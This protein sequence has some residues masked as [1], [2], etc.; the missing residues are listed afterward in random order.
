MV[1]DDFDDDGKVVTKV[2]WLEEPAAFARKS[3]G[4]FESLK[5]DIGWISV[6]FEI[7]NGF[8]GD[9]GWV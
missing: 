4:G 7:E 5:M 6:G 3:W 1:D 2:V 9:F 8:V